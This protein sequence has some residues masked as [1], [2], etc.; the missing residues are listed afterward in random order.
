M[1]FTPFDPGAEARE[2]RMEAQSNRGAD[3]A[4]LYSQRDRMSG[5][6]T[7]TVLRSLEP[8]SEHRLVYF[9]ADTYVIADMLRK[10]AIQDARAL[11]L[12]I[13]T[14]RI[15]ITTLREWY[16]HKG[17]GLDGDELRV[18]VDHTAGGD[19][20]ATRAYEF[21]VGARQAPPPPA[22]ARRRRPKHGTAAITLTSAAFLLAATF[23][24][25]VTS[26]M[27]GF[28]LCSVLCSVWAGIREFREARLAV[29][30]PT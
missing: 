22:P 3:A 1:T 7:R 23:S 24:G 2:R 16:D 15:R 12:E 26:T 18:F 8:I 27:G 14:S 4:W 25:D 9:I 6:T 13:D 29:S 28:M 19:E 5:R 20:E 10:A 30:R 21:A 17:Y 11:G